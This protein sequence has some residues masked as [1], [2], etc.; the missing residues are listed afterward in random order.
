MQVLLFKNR[1]IKGAINEVIFSILVMD[2]L[3]KI[4]S[5]DESSTRY[6]CRI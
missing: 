6:R 3:Y 4:V 1:S 5:Q 2:F